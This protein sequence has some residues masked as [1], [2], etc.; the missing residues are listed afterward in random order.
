MLKVSTI[1]E[2]MTSSIS[3]SDSVYGIISAIEYKSENIKVGDERILIVIL[4]SSDGVFVET[5]FFSTL[6]IGNVP[7]VGKKIDIVTQGDYKSVRIID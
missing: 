6:G 1:K 5:F 4:E 3:L 2:D 7:E